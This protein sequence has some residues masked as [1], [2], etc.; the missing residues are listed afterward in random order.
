MEYS[1]AHFETEA[2][3][4]CLNFLQIGIPYRLDV[5]L[6]ERFLCEST[7][8]FQTSGVSFVQ[9]WQL[10]KPVDYVTKISESLHIGAVVQEFVIGDEFSKGPYTAT[11]L[12]GNDQRRFAIE[13]STYSAPSAP[14]LPP[15]ETITVANET[16]RMCKNSSNVTRPIPVVSTALETFSLPSGHDTAFVR[17][18]NSLDYEATKTYDLL[19]EITDQDSSQK[20]NVSIKVLNFKSGFETVLGDE[21]KFE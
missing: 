16:V 20:G 1:R 13:D 18:N 21:P 4:F 15:E 9:P 11:I 8:L 17:L 14:V 5:F 6:A 2:T 10:T 3:Y 12:S 7:F 19:V